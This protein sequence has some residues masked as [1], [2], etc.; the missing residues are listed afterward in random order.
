MDFIAFNRELSLSVKRVAE[1]P[2]DFA[3]FQLRVVRTPE[4][5][6]RLKAIRPDVLKVLQALAAWDEK[7]G[8]HQMADALAVALRPMFDPRKSAWPL[9]GDLVVLPPLAEPVTLEFATPLQA[10]GEEAG[11]ASAQFLKANSGEGSP[12]GT[13]APDPLSA[14]A[15]IETLTEQ[16]VEHFVQTLWYLK[17][18]SALM[19]KQDKLRDGPGDTAAGPGRVDDFRLAQPDPQQPA[20]DPARHVADE[21]PRP[22]G[23]GPGEVAGLGRQRRF[24]APA[25]HRHV[26][27][28]GGVFDPESGSSS[29][30]LP[31]IYRL[32]V[33]GSKVGP[34]TWPFGSVNA[35]KAGRG[36]KLYANLCASCHIDPANAPFAPGGTLPDWLPDWLYD[37]APAPG[38]AAGAPSDP[39]KF[40]GTDPNRA[41][42]FVFDMQK[43]P[44]P[45]AWTRAW[46]SS[47]SCSSSRATSPPGRPGDCKATGRR[48]GGRPGN[49]PSGP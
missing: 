34:P 29:I 45:P 21:L 11:P 36:A 3:A 6:E 33:I 47:R 4:E 24:H 46:R 32:E 1:H 8:A 5:A 10:I 41:M 38:G 25:E 31:D 15:K 9:A 42:N 19:A 28:M 17:Q 39:S 27:R 16:L 23:D 13:L 40:V 44:A 43:M 37:P 48:P 12:L 22:L 26:H 35:E 14:V 18:S 2:G 49:T 7:D 20:A 30:S